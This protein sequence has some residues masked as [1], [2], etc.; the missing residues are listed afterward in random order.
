[1]RSHVLGWQ[2]ILFSSSQHEPIH[3][4]VVVVCPACNP[5]KSSSS[6][7]KSCEMTQRQII[8]MG[9]SWQINGNPREETYIETKQHSAQTPHV[10]TSINSGSGCHW[11]HQ[12]CLV[13][14]CSREAAALR[15]RLRGK[16]QAKELPNAP[17]ASNMAGW[18]IP[19]Q[20]M[21]IQIINQ[22]RNIKN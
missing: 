7:A 2:Q 3:I 10:G 5:P 17:E 11:S 19:E 14:F 15:Y 6:L 1:M 21:G 16:L 12:A 9:G 13:P 22:K 20:K 4:E 8:F 18:D